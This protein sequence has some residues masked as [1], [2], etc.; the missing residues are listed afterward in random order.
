LRQRPEAVFLDAGNVL[1][2]IDYVTM[3]RVVGNSGPDVA[4]E[5]LRRAE[6][7]ARVRLGEEVGVEA[8]PISTESDS[9]FRR[10][11]TLILEEAALDL[12]RDSIERAFAEIEDYHRAHNLWGCP[13]PSVD[14]VL[15]ELRRQGVKLAV[16]SNSDGRLEELL[17]RF[18]LCRYFDAILDST[19]EGVEKPDPEI[20]R[21]AAERVGAAPQ[22]AVHV[23]DLYWVDVVGARAAGVEPV[24]IDPAGLWP[25]SD[26]VKIRDLTAVPELVRH[27]PGVP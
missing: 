12:E 9:L 4:P 21:I 23:G 24:L 25:Q 11:V 7:A 6:W 10:F 19:V 17:D 8:N 15:E 1:V 22:R 26:C 14:R 3:A 27:A 20:F 2:Q 18:A 13:H 5:R 16:V